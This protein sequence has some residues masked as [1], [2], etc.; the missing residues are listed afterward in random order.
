M[1]GEQRGQVPGL[2]G[3]YADGGDA[4]EAR[5]VDSDADSVM[6]MACNDDA[7]VAHGVDLGSGWQ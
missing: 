4:P 1:R 6:S 7:L 2:I 3:V 5:V